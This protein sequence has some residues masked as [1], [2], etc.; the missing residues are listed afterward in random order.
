MK[1][2]ARTNFFSLNRILLNRGVRETMPDHFAWRLKVDGF[3]PL[4]IER[5]GTG[6][7]DLPLLSVMHWYLQNG[8]LMRDPDVELEAKWSGSDTK[9]VFYPTYYR[10]DNLGIYD[11]LVW[12]NEDQ[13]KCRPTR[14]HSVCSFCETWSSNLKQQGFVELSQL[15]DFLT[16]TQ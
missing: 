13:L 3:M 1:L 10:Q 9:W 11:E 15:P 8:D 4:S 6:P 5:I 12:R 14:I 16:R 2:R 7:R